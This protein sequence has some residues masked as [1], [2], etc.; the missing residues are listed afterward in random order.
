MY[1]ILENLIGYTGTNTN[2]YSYIM[3]GCIAIVCIFVAC[4]TD[5][6]YRI[7]RHFWRR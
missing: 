1:A 7:F 3:Y 5:M 2:Y 4:F 6:I